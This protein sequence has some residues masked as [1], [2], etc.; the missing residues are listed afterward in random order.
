MNLK[1]ATA[2]SLS[3]NTEIVEI[4]MPSEKNSSY[5]KLSVNYLEKQAHDV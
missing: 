3:K 4:L 5:M 1:S 2:L